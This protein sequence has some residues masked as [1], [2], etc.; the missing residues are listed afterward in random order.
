MG[1]GK[2]SLDS[3][4]QVPWPESE[5]RTPLE[6]GLDGRKANEILDWKI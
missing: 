2:I 1:G 5:V 6:N 3:R 4:L